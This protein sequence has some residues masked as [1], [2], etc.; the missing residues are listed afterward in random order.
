MLSC[1]RH[2][3]YLPDDVH[4]LNCAFMSPLA[5]PVEQAGIEGIRLKRNPAQIIARD[6]FE[7]S[8]AVRREFAAIIGTSDPRRISIIPA[9]SYAIATAARNLAAP[10]GSEIVVLF[11]QFP[12]NIYTWRRLASER[13][14]KLQVVLP[15]DDEAR[16]GHRWNERILDAISKRTA[17]VCIPIVHWVDG[18][19]FDVRAIGE[20]ARDVEAAF[21]ID[22]TQSIGAL[23]FD[24]T[25]VKPDLLVCAGY[26]WL[27]GPY[28]VGMAYWSNLFDRGTP[29]EENWIVRQGSR[30]FSGLVE[31]EDQYQEGAVR[32]DV[33]ERSNFA[34]MPMMLQGLKLVRSLRPDRIQEYCRHL[35]REA[36]SEVVEMGYRLESD[37]FRSDHL[38]GIRAPVALSLDRLKDALRERNVSVSIRGSAIRVAPNVY[39][40]GRDIDALVDALRVCVTTNRSSV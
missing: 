15:P 7:A 20:R 6:F 38:F 13:G 28:S 27:M 24:V 2:Q 9:V 31:Y 36:L 8:D 17:A 37:A 19:Q 11:E 35:T 40:D 1:Q 32:F 26:K 14:L 29:L 30:D 18:T 10:S 34:L 12:S 23:P 21:I 22:G 16:R 33:G 3:F 39:N 25:E 5:K 4:Y